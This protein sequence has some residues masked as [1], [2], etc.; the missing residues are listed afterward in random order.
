V[1]AELEARL[2]QAVE[3]LPEGLRDHIH[4]VEDEAER[5][6]RIH[7]VDAERVRLAVLGHDLVRDKSDEELLAL[8][9]RY[10]VEPDKVQAATPILLHGPIAAAILVKDYGV[11]DAE[12]LAGV[13][14]HTTGRAGMSRLEQVLF[15]ADK[16]EPHKQ[17]RNPELSQVRDLA[18]TNLDAAVLRYLDFNLEQSLQRRW[19]V[20]PMSL[21]ARNQLLH[22][23]R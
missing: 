12:I 6:A 23:L 2:R 16:I 10:G 1:S 5:L 18:Q 4:R 20:H 17:T 7:A 22:Q 21:E 14:C 13:D 19:L 8:A 3:A 15:V 11:Q 9:P